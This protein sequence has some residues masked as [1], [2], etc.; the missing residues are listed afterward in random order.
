MFFFVLTCNYVRHHTYTSRLLES[1]PPLLL[2]RGAS[3]KIY[4]TFLMKENYMHTKKL[5]GA[6]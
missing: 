1:I 2:R 4:E 3:K 6:A 5:D